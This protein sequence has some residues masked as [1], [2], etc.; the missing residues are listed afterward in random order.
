MGD[1]CDGIWKDYDYGF[2]TEVDIQVFFKVL[3]PLHDFDKGVKIDSHSN[4]FIL[5]RLNYNKMVRLLNEDYLSIDLKL[6]ESP[7]GFITYE[8]Y[9]RDIIKGGT[10]GF[11][12]GMKRDIGL[13]GDLI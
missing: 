7:Y 4:R 12:K 2:D 9:G 11:T 5:T 8:Q 1:F 3:S 13:I 10:R 6:K